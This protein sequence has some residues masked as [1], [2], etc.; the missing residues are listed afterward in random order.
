MSFWNTSSANITVE[1]KRGLHYE[2]YRISEVILKQGK[3][4]KSY[5][6]FL[7]TIAVLMLTTAPIVVALSNICW[8]C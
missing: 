5:T 7:R 4:M 6:N 2:P 3:L 8:K 1:P